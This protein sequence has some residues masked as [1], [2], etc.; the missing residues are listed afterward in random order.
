MFP[1]ISTACLWVS[2]PQTPVIVETLSGEVSAACLKTAPPRTSSMPSWS[3][4]AAAAVEPLDLLVHLSNP[5]SGA[6][7][8]VHVVTAS[9]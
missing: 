3:L 9:G 1:L 8:H 6:S 5:C 7:T 4:V 2:G